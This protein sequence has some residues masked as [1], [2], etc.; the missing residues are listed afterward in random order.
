MLSQ[1]ESLMKN[2]DATIRSVLERFP[3]VVQGLSESSQSMAEGSLSVRGM[4]ESVLVHLQ[5][6]DRMVQ[7]LAA[8]FK[9][10]ERLSSTLR[11]QAKRIEHGEQPDLFDAKAWIAEL[12]Q[13]YTTLEQHDSR[14]PAGK[15][16]VADNEITFF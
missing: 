11:G 7:I 16:H 14:Q 8:V 12:E 10:I 4:V 6:Q 2:S 15:G 3:G 1:N 5:F 13:T 9:D